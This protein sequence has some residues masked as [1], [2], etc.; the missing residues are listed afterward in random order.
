MSSEI[1]VAETWLYET[2]NGDETLMGSDEGELGVTGVHSEKPTK[3]GSTAPEPPYVVYSLASPGSDVMG[4]TTQ[5][6]WSGL[7]YLVKAVGEGNSLA[8]LN[9]IAARI[10]TLL[11]GKGGSPTGGGTVL[12]CVRVRPVSYAE[13]LGNNRY[14]RHL[15]GIY[16]LEVQA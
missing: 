10:D 4:A 7:D 9:D 8:A 1:V 6:I 5:R 3:V 11:H 2:L 13:Q 12:S 16:R 14:Y 15:G